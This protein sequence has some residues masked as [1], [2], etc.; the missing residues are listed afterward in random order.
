MPP[1]EEETG[2]QSYIV[3]T[4]I[5]LYGGTLKDTLT[6]NRCDLPITNSTDLTPLEIYSLYENKLLS[7]WGLPPD[8]NSYAASHPRLSLSCSGTSPFQSVWMKFRSAHLRPMKLQN[9]ER[10]FLFV[11]V[12]SPASP[13]R[14]L[15]CLAVSWRHLKAE[16]ER[17]FELLE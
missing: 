11:L 3:A 17:I 15:A 10:I 6:R 2:R 4:G 9:G 8:H 12:P 13:S 1:S 14:L 5:Y 16:Q 7:G